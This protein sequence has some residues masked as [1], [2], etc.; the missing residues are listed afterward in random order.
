MFTRSFHCCIGLLMVVILAPACREEIQLREVV[1]DTH[2]VIEGQITNERMEH[3]VHVHRSGSFGAKE[4]P[5]PVSGLQLVLTGPGINILLRETAPG[6]YRTDSLAG[7]P[8]A[9]YSLQVTDGNT[10]YRARDTLPFLPDPFEPMVFSRQGA[11]YDFEFR[12]HQFG[13]SCPN[14]WEL[15]ILRDSIPASLQGIDPE[16]LGQQVGIEVSADYGYHF[17]YYTHPSVE[18]SGLMNFDIPHFYGFNP[19]F[20][21][22]QKKYALSPAYYRFLR[23][24]FMETEWRGTLF[25]TTPANITGNFTG[26]ALGYFRTLSVISQEFQVD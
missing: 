13:F 25:A 24:V 22:L 3:S 10:V 1:P 26:G 21:V 8:G 20:R 6:V 5:E 15:H 19:G 2:L 9:A 7:V 16:K 17:T 11:Y 18:A 23:S 12:R 4:M 14:R